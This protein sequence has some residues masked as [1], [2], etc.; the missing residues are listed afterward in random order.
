MISTQRSFRKII[1]GLGQGRCK[2][3][4]GM[5]RWRARLEAGTPEQ[6]LNVARA[7]SQELKY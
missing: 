6:Q 2:R 4:S 3:G 7:T 5:A 1:G